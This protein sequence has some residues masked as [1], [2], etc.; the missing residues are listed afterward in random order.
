VDLLILF[1]D[2]YDVVRNVE[3]YRQQDNSKLDQVL[4]P[5]SGWRSMWDQLDNRQRGNIRRK[6]AEIYKNQLG[7]R[8][9]Y[10]KFGEE[11]IK[12][13]TTPLYTLIYASKHERGLD[14]WEK[15]STKD[16]SGQLDLF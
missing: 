6:F 10:K 3:F 5:N 9:G 15:I 12:N 14:F 4:G 16:P 2:A 8:L 11:T 7:R 1:A 13:G